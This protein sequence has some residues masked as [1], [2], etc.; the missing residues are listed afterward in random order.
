MS[1][2]F[3]HV[4]DIHFGQER[5]DAVHINRDV[6]EQLI[7]DAAEVV[8]RVGG[9]G[10]G[11]ILVTGDIA[12]SGTST[13]YEE[14]GHWLDALAHKIGCPIHRVQMV[15]GNHDLDRDK[16]SIGGTKLL[17]HIRAG[18]PAE[19]EQVISNANDRATLFSRFEN[20]GRFCIGYGCDLDE[21]A[22]FATNLRVDLAPGRAIRFIRLNSSLLCTGR[23]GREEARTDDRCAAV[24]HPASSGRGQRRARSS[25]DALV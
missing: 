16:L 4:S 14:A 20:Y 12:Y 9:G 22:K 8:E 25:P 18:G 13:Q 1:A 2:I 23:G 3:I 5:D 7:I 21:D 24:H 6:K 17:D 19:Y 15:P 11:G 10:A